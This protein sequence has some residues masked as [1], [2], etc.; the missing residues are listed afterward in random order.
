MEPV[1]LMAE[2]VENAGLWG[3]AAGATI[4]SV[5]WF[6]HDKV[7][8]LLPEW[9]RWGRLHMAVRLALVGLS[10]LATSMAAAFGAGL[11][12]K[13]AAFAAIPAVI[14]AVMGHKASKAVGHGL[15]R[16]AEYGKQ[17]YSPS[18]ARRVLDTAG[19]LPLDRNSSRIRFP[20]DKHA[21][22]RPRTRRT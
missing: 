10:A 9:M 16:E 15:Q 13:T 7:Q 2:L 14:T 11:S 6:R 1:T 20:G 19:V 18:A 12:P 4:L 3:A 21:A 5:R 17:T 8:R 22:T